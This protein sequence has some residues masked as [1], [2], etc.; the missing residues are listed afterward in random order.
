MCPY[1]LMSSSITAKPQPSPPQK[2]IPRAYSLHVLHGASPKSRKGGQEGGCGHKPEVEEGHLAEVAEGGIVPVKQQGC[3]E[4][5]EHLHHTAPAG[6]CWG[7]QPRLREQ[8]EWRRGCHGA[9]PV[10]QRHWQSSTWA[11]GAGPGEGAVLSHPVRSLEDGL[12]PTGGAGHPPKG[13]ERW[14]SQHWGPWVPQGVT[15]D[16]SPPA[17]LKAIAVP[18]A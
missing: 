9:W 5:Q 1:D 17:L 14:L 10:N 13:G 7:A 4:E 8:G 11:F 6:G 15:A 18:P 3:Q 12:A 16:E 2:H